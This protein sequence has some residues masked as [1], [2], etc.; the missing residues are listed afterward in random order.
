MSGPMALEPGGAA[1]DT[2]SLRLAGDRPPA[3]T[4]RGHGADQNAVDRLAAE[5]ADGIG[6]PSTRTR[7]PHCW[8]RR[9]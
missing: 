8:N 3:L 9:G 4:A 1:G 5:L 6:R 2:L 7:W